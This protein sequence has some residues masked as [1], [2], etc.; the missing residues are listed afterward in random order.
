MK[1][2]VATLLLLAGLLISAG[3]RAESP[4][5]E[6]AALRDQGD[7]KGAA[8]VLA[9]ALK[10]H[11]LSTEQRKDL[12]FQADVLERIKQDYPFSKDGLFEKLSASVK[13]LTRPEFDRWMA[14]GRFDSKTI[15]GQT[16]YVSTSV[17]NLY[18]RDPSLNSRRLDKKDDVLEQK[19]R[20]EISRDIK[21]AVQAGR[22]PY[23]LPHHFV[24]T[25]KTTVA[26]DAVP[27]GEVVRAWLPIPR[28]YPFQD[29]F[30]LIA[31]SS[32]VKELGLDSSPIRSA[33]LEQPAVEGK[34]DEFTVTYSF[35][36]DGIYFDLKPQDSRPADLSDP[37]LKKFASEAPHV[38]FTDRIKRLANQIA[39]TETNQVL[40]AR[41]FYNWVTGNI[42]YSFSREY[43]TLANLSD[44][45]LTNR[46]G[47]CGQEAMLFITLCRSRGIPARWQTGW[48]LFPNAKNMHDWSE[49]YLAPYGW[50]PVDA[51]AGLYATRYCSALTGPERQELRDFYFGGLDYYR[52]AAN[53]DHSQELVPPKKTMRSDDVDFQRGEVEWGNSNLYFDKYSFGLNVEELK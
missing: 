34:P 26:E 29:Q 36:R 23:V 40:E 8:A 45:C 22:T 19:G 31:S 3:A 27:A 10:S 20:L 28:Q 1:V 35:T 43:S 41:A 7:F 18:F 44:Y 48:D 53:G 46:Y 39:G 5:S 12:A 25:M 47:D 6:A 52:M 11:D 37:I 16:L 42:L 4:A 38:V 9:E 51:W 32:P 21:R 17:A 13:D 24:C 2:R 15:D 49:I 33:Y 50:V 30:K 14:E